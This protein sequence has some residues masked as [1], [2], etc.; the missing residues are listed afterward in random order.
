MQ[1]Q[2]RLT[3]R[4]ANHRSTSP[5]APCGQ[6][7]RVQRGWLY[8]V[9]AHFSSPAAAHSHPQSPYLGILLWFLLGTFLP[10]VPLVR[11]VK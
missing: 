6:S 3:A 11:N 5:G 2:A 9:S 8:I 4:A 10:L 7:A 1:I